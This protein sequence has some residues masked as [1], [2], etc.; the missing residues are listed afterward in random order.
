M[1][2]PESRS[3]DLASVPFHRAGTQ[4]DGG[5]TEA[6]NG[7]AERSATH[8]ATRSI[9]LLLYPGVVAKTRVPFGPGSVN[10]A[11]STRLLPSRDRETSEVLQSR[12]NHG[13][14]H[15]PRKARTVVPKDFQLC[16][17]DPL[18]HCG[19]TITGAV[20]FGPAWIRWNM[21]SWWS[22]SS[23]SEEHTSELQSPMYIVC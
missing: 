3:S 5:A 9:I 14:F 8:R 18:C 6:S 4:A 15:R 2:V 1:G 12:G 11:K 19:R 21:A 7:I 20:L 22:C 16:R 23:R 17:P 13:N 10:L